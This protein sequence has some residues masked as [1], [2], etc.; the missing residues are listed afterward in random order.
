MAADPL[1]PR[2]GPPVFGRSEILEESS[3]LLDAAA[4]GQGSILILEGPDGVG[5]S[6]FLG[7]VVAQAVGKRFRVLEARARASDLP[8]PYGLLRELIASIPQRTPAPGGPTTDPRELVPIFLAPLSTAPELPA[9]GPDRSRG[10]EAEADAL[11]S[12]LSDPG[13]RLRGERRGLYDRLLDFFRENAEQHPV[14]L[15]IDD[16]QWADRASLDFLVALSHALARER[17]ALV[18]SIIPGGEIS[19]ESSAAVEPILRSPA[20]RVLALRPLTEVE[21]GEYARW[22][23]G[24]RDPAPEALRRWYAQTEGNPQLIE[25][26]VRLQGRSTLPSSG[27]PLDLHALLRR[28]YEALPESDRR[29]LV[30]AAVLGR[31]FRVGAVTRASGAPEEEVTESLERLAKAGLLRERGEETYEF[32]SDRLRTDVYG[33]LTETRRGI[34]HR[35]VLSALE[36]GGPEGPASVFD[37]ARH[38]YLGREDP[39]S[40]EYNRRAAE[41]AADALAFDEAA[42]YLERALESQRRLARRDSSLELRLLIELGRLLDEL[43]DLKRAESL[44]EDAVAR[45]RASETGERDLAL[46][47]LGL[48]RVRSDRVDLASAQ[49]LAAEAFEILERAADPRGVM[50]AHRVLGVTLYRL[51]DLD[52]A[53]RHQRAELDLAEAKGTPTERGHAL[54]DLANTFISRGPDRLPEALELFDRADRI[55]AEGKDDTAR[56]RVLMNRGL[57]YHNTG[58]LAESL[59]DLREASEAAERSRSRVWIGYTQ[60]NLAQVLTEMHDV[61]SG[62]R[63]LDRGLSLLE[64]LGD[65]LAAQTGRMIRGMLAEEEGR[66]DEADAEYGEAIEI[67]RELE[68]GPD[69][70]ESLFRRARLAERRGARTEAHRYLEESFALGLESWKPDLAPAARRLAGDIGLRRGARSP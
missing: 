50:A 62:R 52:G 61:T 37:L 4:R 38:A 67:A 45:A 25:Q 20:S 41:A 63:A 26:L 9:S 39:K 36:T 30:Y 35:K 23:L 54:I 58:R 14:L 43:G 21:L 2:R 56:A 66:L 64:P 48:A 6:T 68:L 28:R 11:L 53:E 18:A 49:R 47:L 51:G 15:A 31:E 3:S 13:D 12:R 34:L 57:L 7:A 33:E 19:V 32:A 29:T 46:A 8:E 69:A 16:L 40:A 42:R 17:I 1:P 70:A 59:A 60:L 24:G 65:R 22:L 10:T 55:F 44:L 5:K 27:E